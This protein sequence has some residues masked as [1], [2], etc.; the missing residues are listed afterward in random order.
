MLSRTQNCLSRAHGDVK[1]V[2]EDR[3]PIPRRQFVSLRASFGGEFA[4]RAD[5]TQ[6]PRGA[7][8]E[9]YFC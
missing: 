8:V 7:G 2:R 3:K 1:K 9:A 4:A 5:G 6:T